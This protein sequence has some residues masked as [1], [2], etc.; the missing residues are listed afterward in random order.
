MWVLEAEG[1]VLQGGCLLYPINIMCESDQDRK[2]NMASSREE[3]PVRQ[4]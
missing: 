4:D 1:E 2:K 3:V